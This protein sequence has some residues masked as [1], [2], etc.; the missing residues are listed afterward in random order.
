[1]GLVADLLTVPREHAALIDIA[2][3]ETAQCFVVRDA[4]LL[5]EALGLRSSA[6]TGRVGFLQ[7]GRDVPDIRL[8]SHVN[9]L[10]IP[11]SV[12]ALRN[13]PRVLASADHLVSTANPDLAD[14]PRQLLGRTLLVADL[15]AARALA[16]LAPGFRFLTPQ[17]E[18]LEADGTLTVGTHHAEA[19]LLSR[20][21]EL[22]ELRDQAVKLDQTIV[23]IEVEL[24]ALRDQI[25]Q[26][27]ARVDA[28]QQERAVLVEQEADL[29]SR[30]G[31][32]RQRRD[33][34]NQE[35]TLS[36]T[37]ISSLERDLRALE[38]SWNDA[39]VRAEAAEQRVQQL[40]VRLQ[41]AEHEIRRREG[42]RQQLQQDTTS[43]SIAVAQAEER[44]AAV[45]EKHRQ[46]RTDWQQR[47]QEKTQTEMRLHDLRDRLEE[48]ERTMLRASAALAQ[49]YLDKEMAERQLAESGRERDQRRTERQQL[50]DQSQAG[51]THWREQQEQA[52]LRELAVNDLCHRRDQLVNRLR[53]DYQLELAELYREAA[54]G[55]DWRAALENREA[56][57]A[58]AATTED[59]EIAELRRKLTRLGSVNLEALKELAELEERAKTLQAQ[60]DDLTNAQRALEDII[61]KINNDSRKLFT[62]SFDAIR[63][64]FQELFRKLFGGGIADIVL[65]DSND[66]LESGIDI[67][68]RPPGKEMRN[69]SLMSGGEKTMTAVALLLAIFRSKP[70]PFCILDEVDAALDESNIGR[71]TAVLREF[72]DLSQ[73]I[74]ITHSKR[75]MSAADVLY[76]V[77]MQESGVS[78]R[79]AVRFE[80]WPEEEATLEMRKAA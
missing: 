79:V 37:E 61:N 52:H 68:A 19:G 12:E 23:E 50:A 25:N 72:L 7:M 6:F 24:T 36:R 54:A 48:S 26:S 18:L 51:R 75:T 29:R 11:W 20:K 30:I 14:L 9:M 41:D 15:A 58:S 13:N 27:D 28:L 55:G 49:W 77:T 76:G 44:L 56:P 16:A 59:E 33:G 21:S 5:D 31:Q 64:H 1:M 69:L 35:V 60:F 2:L 42:E 67:I 10:R 34:L 40:E 65:E 74:L 71:F 22:R 62:E 57:S 43:A 3:G 70:S 17:G 53:E 4:A 80:D 38:A 39:R 32:H 45:R 63:G 78:K 8:P 46:I 66:I 73:F 47:S